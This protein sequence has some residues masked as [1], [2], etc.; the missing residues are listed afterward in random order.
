MNEILVNSGFIKF[1]GSDFKLLDI[2]NAVYKY[3]SKTYRSEYIYKNAIA[4]KILLGRHSLNTSFMLTEF[5][6]GNCKADVAIFNGTSNVYEIK[7][8]LDSLERLENQIAEYQQFFDKVHIITAPSQT[9]KISKSVESSIGILELTPRNTIKTL[10]QAKS[11]KKRVSPETIFDSLR[12]SEY[13][14]IIEKHYGSIPEMPNTQIYKECKTIFRKISPELAHDS[15][16][17]LLKQRGNSYGLKNFIESVPYSL[18]AI[19]LN[20]C[21]KEKDANSFIDILNSSYPCLC[22]NVA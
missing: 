7:T 12:K 9:N 6:V 1:L 13:L 21:L 11:G 19:A 20:S 15:M 16:V 8:E 2:F 17:P 14:S 4:N 3:L 5:R 10:Q 22:S 18:K